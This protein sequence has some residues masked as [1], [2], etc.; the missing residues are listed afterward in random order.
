ML[1]FEIILE[2]NQV[3]S[4]FRKNMINRP[5]FMQSD[6]NGAIGFTLKKRLICF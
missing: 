5:T 3:F 6:I 1:P 4:W 2:I